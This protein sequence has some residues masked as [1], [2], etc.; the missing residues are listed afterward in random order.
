MS[1]ITGILY[2]DGRLMSPSIIQNMNDCLS[3]RGP[4]GSALWNNDTVAIGHQM[5]YTTSESLHEMLPFYDEETQIAITADARIDNRKDLAIELDISDNEDIS[6][7]Y[8]I[9]K[10][11]EMWGENCPKHLLGDFVFGIWDN[12]ENKLFCARDHMGVKPLY[13]YLNE[14]I[15]LFSTEIKAL[16]N[17]SEVPREL[18]EKKLALYLNRDILDKEQTFYKDIKS[19][20]A[21]HFLKITSEKFTKEIYWKLD[22]NLDLK[23]DSEE[24]YAKAFKDIFTEAVRCRLRSHYPIGFELSGGL[25]SSSIVCM[26]KKILKQEDP[27]NFEV[28]NSYSR[29]YDKISECDESLYIKKVLDTG[30]INPTFLNGITSAL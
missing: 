1:S 12:K 18:N 15:F 21:A 16:F 29:V 23:M 19:L 24:D 25:D 6:D 28:I 5:L 8:F 17:L 7:S 2:R 10:S 27:E 13:Y 22:P 30:N 11:Y 26:A 9:L 4:D 3:H 14:N 20:P